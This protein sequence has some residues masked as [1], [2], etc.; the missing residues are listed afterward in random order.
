MSF[1][2][3]TR[4]VALFEEAKG[5]RVDGAASPRVTTLLFFCLS[6]WLV[7]KQNSHEVINV[8][9]EKYHAGINCRKSVCVWGGCR[10]RIEE[11]PCVF[12]VCFGWVAARLRTKTFAS[13]LV[14]FPRPLLFLKNNFSNFS[15]PGEVEPENNIQ[16]YHIGVCHTYLMC[17]LEARYCMYDMHIP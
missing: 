17:L 4:Y 8:C 16:K 5:P 11:R 3:S 10:V 6:F 1:H 15:K 9:R 7:K 13:L 12:A 2:G 14:L